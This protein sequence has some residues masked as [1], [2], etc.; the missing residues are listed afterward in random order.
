MFEN[1]GKGS[2][3]VIAAALP[4]VEKTVTDTGQMLR[5]VLTESV[6]PAIAEVVA[7]FEAQC[8]RLDGAEVT[9][10]PSGPITVTVTLPTFTLKVSAPLKP[11]A[12]GPA[13]DS[14]VTVSG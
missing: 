2:A 10:T 8:D 4:G 11:T 13:A 12:G 5:L 7:T 9:L 3:D 1:I 6:L 14:S